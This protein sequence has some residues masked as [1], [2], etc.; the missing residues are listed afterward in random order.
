MNILYVFPH[1]D[2][3]SFGPSPVMYRQVQ[4]GHRVYL[5]TLTRGGATRERHKLGLGIDDMGL[6]RVKEME[7]VNAILNL[8]G[9]TILN[10]ED[11]GLSAMNPLDLEDI[12]IRHIEQ[13][14]ADIM[15]TY[16][17]HGI[18]GHPDHLVIH[19][20]AKRVY[21]NM[22]RNGGPLRRLAFFTLEK[23]EGEIG[24]PNA[25]YSESQD[26]DCV[27]LLTETETN[28]LKSTLACYAT[29]REVIEKYDVIR[30]IGTRVNFEFWD[31]HFDPVVH[32]LTYGL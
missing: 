23:P 14:Q 6:L 1:P 30:Q 18:S 11:G 32:D 28:I 4:E 3:E 5:L 17:Q 7:K 13:T 25:R 27:I 24:N 16:P 12:L 15:V 8:S 9:M 20:V 29:Y 22:K 2:D 19:A 10:L 31:E 21:C 26:I